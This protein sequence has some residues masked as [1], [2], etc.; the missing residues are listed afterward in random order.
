MG[1]MP[2]Q[3]LLFG[4]SELSCFYRLWV[5]LFL[6]MF[7][8]EVKCHSEQPKLLLQCLSPSHCWV[9]VLSKF[10]GVVILLISEPYQDSS[11]CIS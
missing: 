11:V 10:Y 1:V 2:I 3:R 4:L 7:Y 5:L 9:L 6:V 8:L